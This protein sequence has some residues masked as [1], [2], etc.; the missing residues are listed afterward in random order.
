MKNGRVLEAVHTEN[1]A[2]PG[3]CPGARLAGIFPTDGRPSVIRTEKEI[4][5]GVY[6]NMLNG[7]K[8][9]VDAG[10]MALDG[11]PVIL[12]IPAGTQPG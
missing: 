2:V 8:V 4:P 1:P 6:E 3:G 12:R 9:E 10:V 5:D 11:D 7:R